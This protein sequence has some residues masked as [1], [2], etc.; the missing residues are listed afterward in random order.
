MTFLG[1]NAAG[2]LNKKESFYHILDSVT[3]AVFFI[4]ESK[5]RLKNKVKHSDYIMFELVRS[6]K[7]GG[8]LLTAVHKNLKPV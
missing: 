1:N 8:G 6:G 3:P 2:L 4:Q 5:C 7:N